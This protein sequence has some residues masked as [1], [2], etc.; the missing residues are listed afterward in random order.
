MTKIM[1][2]WSSKYCV[3]PFPNEACVTSGCCSLVFRAIMLWMGVILFKKIFSLETHL[4]PS[5][6]AQPQRIVLLNERKGMPPLILSVVPIIFCLSEII[7]F[8]ILFIS[9]SCSCCRSKGAFRL[10]LDGIYEHKQFY[11]SL[12]FYSS[13]RKCEGGR[14]SNESS[15]FLTLI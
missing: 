4:L 7:W 14:K 3:K 8:I 12:S 13:L 5:T 15:I 9:F 1:R 10:E 11:Y 6:P 2:E